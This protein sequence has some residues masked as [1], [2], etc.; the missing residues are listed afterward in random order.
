[1]SHSVPN[2]VGW[3][4]SEA[5]LAVSG[6]MPQSQRAARPSSKVVTVVVLS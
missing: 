1:M 3:E 2:A 4:V 5:V 6:T